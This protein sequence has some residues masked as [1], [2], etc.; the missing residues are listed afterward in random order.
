MPG[1]DY[2]LIR[3]RPGAPVVIDTDG[4]MR[5]TGA[6]LGDSTSTLFADGRF[7]VGSPTEALLHRMELDGSFTSVRLDAPYYTSFHHELAPGKTGMLAELDAR[8]GGV[9]R[10]ECSITTPARAAGC[11]ATPPR[12]G[13]STTR[14]CAPSRYQIDEQARSARE[15]WTYERNRERYSD[16]CSSV[17]ES[18]PGNYLVAY[19]VAEGRTQARLLAVDSLGRVAFDFAYP[20][21]LCDS[22]F[23]AQP[24]AWTDLV[25]R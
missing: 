20:T 24:L 15:V 9:E 4:Q 5:R 23:S 2:I 22:V 7:Y 19:S 1:F 10:I 12:T 6:G 13:T 17:G 8:D 21:Y 16:I 18:T 25:L 3:N 14:R 11:S